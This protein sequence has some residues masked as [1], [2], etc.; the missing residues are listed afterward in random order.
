VVRYAKEQNSIQPPSFWQSIYELFQ[1]QSSRRPFERS[2]AFLVGVSEYQHLGELQWVRKDLEN[3][4][5]YL[6]NQGGFDIVYEAREN[7]VTTNLIEDYMFNVLPGELTDRDRLLFFYSGH[8]TDVGGTAGYLQFSQAQQFY[9][10]SQYLAVTRCHEWSKVNKAK[11]ILFVLDSCMSGMGWDPKE[12]GLINVDESLLSAFSESR[13][14]HVMTAGT[15]RELAFQITTSREQGYSV[16][17][18]A[19]L[20]TLASE[21]IHPG[22]MILEEV[23]AG[24]R[25]RVGRFTSQS[26]RKMTPRLWDLGSDDDTGTFVFMNPAERTARAPEKLTEKLAVVLK[27]SDVMSPSGP[28]GPHL[29]MAAIAYASLK[30]SS[31]WRAI[32]RFVSEYGDV[33]GAGWMVEVLRSKLSR[34]NP[35]DEQFYVWIPPGDFLMGCSVGDL[36]CHPDEKPPHRVTFNEGFWLG[37]NEVTRASYQKVLSRIPSSTTEG[38][39]P[40]NVS[41]GEAQHYCETIGGRLPTEAEWEYAAR[42]GASEARYGALDDIAWY[43]LTSRGKVQSVAQKQPNA[44]GLYDT[45]GN[46]W[47]WT[48]E[49]VDE[50]SN[51]YEP[52]PD[53]DKTGRHRLRILRGGSW[54]SNASSLR[55]SYRS[56]FLEVVKGRLIGFRCVWREATKE[57]NALLDSTEAKKEEPSLLP[58]PGAV[59][60]NPIDGVPYAWIPPGE[61]QMG[62]PVDQF[63]QED[64]KPSRLVAISSGFWLGKTEVT[65]AAYDRIIRAAPSR[66]YG[67]EF[68]VDNVNWIEAQQYCSAVGGRLPTEAEWE[69][70]ARAGSVEALYGDLDEIAWHN[71]NS[72]RKTHPVG[73]KQP[74]AWGLHDMFGNVSEWT[75]DWYSSNYYETRPVPDLDPLGPATGKERVLRGTSRTGVRFLI[76]ASYR[77]RELPSLRSDTIGF[78]CTRKALPSLEILN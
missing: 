39:L 74:N 63:C 41:W 5:N 52:T 38:D 18:Q 54:T 28:G 37:R 43:D 1:W 59:R 2:V 21:S 46:L 57:N 36:E 4:R 64:E 14:R 15:A 56:M 44:W 69:Y 10:A 34:T 42:A 3:V 77:F 22:F 49:A 68:P 27:T 61:F 72:E 35:R 24:V 75:G 50:N 6:L 78:R 11:H 70:A 65:Q 55:V 60:R 32:A 53:A 8:G 26:G 48:A 76:R 67:A 23:I 71:E 51:T 29:Q 20:A 45:L 31:N 73:M 66:Y 58:S 19:F 33:P 30:E 12:G 9:D 25:A 13:S 40:V 47:E 17:T 7:I 62:C 16:F